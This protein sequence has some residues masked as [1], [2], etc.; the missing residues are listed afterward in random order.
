MLILLKARQRKTSDPSH[1]KSQGHRGHSESHGHGQG[2]PAHDREGQGHGST[3]KGI[4]NMTV[5]EEER[6][7]IDRKLAVAGDERKI[8][9]LD[10]GKTGYRGLWFCICL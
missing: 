3:F 6:R 7:A 10:P 4:L 1:N 9:T 2:Q 5:S 8:L